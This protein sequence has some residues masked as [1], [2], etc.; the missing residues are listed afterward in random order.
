MG[1]LNLPIPMQTNTD[2]PIIQ[3]ADDTLI[4]LEGD[5]RQLM[6]LKSVINTFSEATG[7]KVNL[8][9]SM[10]L[11]INVSDQKLDFLAN[12]F[13]CSKGTFP[14]TY[15]GLP[16]GLTK[17]LIHDYMP[18]LNKCEARLG[19]I[20]TFLTQAGR[21]EVTNAVLSALP[22]FYMCTLEIPKTVIKRI[23]TLRR[24]CLWRGNEANARKPPKAAWKL[25]CKSKAEGGLGII[26]IEEQNKA[27][28]LKNLDKFFN[29]SDVPWVQMIWEKYYK[30][31]KLPNH[32]RKGSFWWRDNLKL[33]QQFKEITAPNLKNGETILFWK[34]KWNGQELNL[35]MPELFSYAKDQQISAK[36]VI[37]STD[38]TQ[39][40]HL[41]LSAQAFNQLQQ[42]TP[43]LQDRTQTQDHD[44][45]KYSWGDQFRSAKAYK[46]MMGHQ[47]VHEAY[48]WLWKSQCQPK[49]KVFFLATMQ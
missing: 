47:Q 6:F 43:M 4:V 29:K 28:L 32:T 20:S 11:P 33:L 31:G 22:T 14:F 13:G 40:F 24:N 9:K 49:H 30:N 35:A 5:T 26:N 15:L 41:P 45:W 38:Y 48:K 27:L 1:L 34:D 19:S 37:S 42:L 44:I 17:P 7:L 2:F 36:K 8:K 3:Y 21:L 18:L 12:T 23:D 16:L 10:M 25:T 46:V 39:L